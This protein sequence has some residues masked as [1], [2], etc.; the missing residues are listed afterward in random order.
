MFDLNHDFN[1]IFKMNRIKFFVLLCDVLR[2]TL[3]FKIFTTKVH[4]ENNHT[5]SHKSHKH[6]L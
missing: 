2:V 6:V 1:K 4:K 5:E 3:W